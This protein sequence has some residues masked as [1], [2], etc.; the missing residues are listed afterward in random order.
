LRLG[1]A[2]ALLA[3]ALVAG[4]AI[5]QPQRSA[6][7]SDSALVAL[8]RGRIADAREQALRAAD[9]NPL[10]VDPLIELAVIENAAARRTAALAAL[11]RAVTVLESQ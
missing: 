2:A 6:S 8:D 4:W 7:A 3:A 1:A 11:E 10:S 9:R 5:W